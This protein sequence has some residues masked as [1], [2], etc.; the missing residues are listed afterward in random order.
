MVPLDETSKKVRVAGVGLDRDGVRRGD[1]MMSPSPSCA[2]WD[3]AV[4]VG[5]TDSVLRSI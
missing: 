1:F 5:S 2:A 3:A 4:L